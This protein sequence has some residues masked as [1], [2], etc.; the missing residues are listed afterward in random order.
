LGADLLAFEQQGFRVV[1]SEEIEELFTLDVWRQRL[2]WRL[3]FW[4]AEIAPDRNADERAGLLRDIDSELE[5][6]A[7]Q[8]PR[9][10]LTSYSVVERA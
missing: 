3:D 9:T 7:A 1:R 5:Q 6:R 4:L 8:F 2:G 10:R